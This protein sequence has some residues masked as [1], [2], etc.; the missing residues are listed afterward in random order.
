MGDN[1][2]ALV[3]RLNQLHEGWKVQCQLIALGQTAVA[4]LVEFLLSPPSMFPQPRCW[5]AEALGIIGGDQTLEGLCKV[6]GI[7]DVTEADP[8]IRFAE[9]TV[10]DCAAEQ[11]ERLGDR[12]AIVPLLQALRRHPLPRAAHALAS[13]D[14]DAAIPLIVQYLEDDFVRDRMALAL[15]AFG[16]KV[17]NPLIET[18]QYRRWLGGEETPASIGRRAAAA[19]VLGQLEDIRAVEELRPLLKEQAPE[20][21][22]EAAV[23]LVHLT[24]KAVFAEAVSE[25]IADLDVEPPRLKWRAEE[26]LCNAG[27]AA[28]CLMAQA[29][30]DTLMDENN[31]GIGYLS[32][33]T[34]IRIIRLLG[35][36]QSPDVISVLH[37][38]AIDSDVE[39][40]AE[41]IRAL[42]QVRDPEGIPML[43]CILQ[44]DENP[45][46]RAV[47][48][49]ALGMFTCEAVVDPLVR[50]LED[51]HP[52]V[53]R[54]A[55]R[56]LATLGSLAKPRLQRAIKQYRWALSLDRQRLVWEARRLLRRLREAR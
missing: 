23:A 21:R 46:M 5:A 25:L 44:K 45:R 15:L 1:V 22:V 31:G 47:A 52:I 8:V 56:A 32:H 24:E 53:R 41:A 20:V 12:R 34:L 55:A 40:R 6:L 51:R 54:A 14:V 9:E 49:E 43:V 11:L 33:E 27:P 50:A 30:E 37:S 3:N 18:L 19:N 4:P 26:G 38:V 48:A 2:R 28:V 16:P 7:H 17:L 42:G 10:R 36:C 39:L 35:Q 29:L 13:F